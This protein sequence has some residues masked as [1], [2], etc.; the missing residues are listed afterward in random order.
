MPEGKLV[1]FI[2]QP[3]LKVVKNDVPVVFKIENFDQ[4]TAIDTRNEF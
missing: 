4:E 1:K 3:V 2:V